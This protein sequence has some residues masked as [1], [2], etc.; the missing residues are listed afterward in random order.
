MPNGNPLSPAQFE[1]CKEITNQRGAVFN[2]PVSGG[3]P[4]PAP[5]SFVN[6]VLSNQLSIEVKKHTGTNISEK[7]PAHQPVPEPPSAELDA[8]INE[9][10]DQVERQIQLK[11]NE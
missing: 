2:F 4:I 8:L 6:A 7:R 10:V 3:P 5:Y 9:V 1:R 11:P